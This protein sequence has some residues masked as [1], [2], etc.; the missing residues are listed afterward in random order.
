MTKRDA[1]FDNAKFLLI[2]LVVFGHFIQSYIDEHTLIRSL[3]LTIYTFH[4]PAFIFI[5]GYFA[6]GISDKGYILNLAKK[7]L[8]PYVIFQILY[9]LYYYYFANGSLMENN[10]FNPYWSLWFLLSM[11]YW[12][13]MIIFFKKFNW[14]YALLISLSISLTIGYF[15]QI[16][17]YL[18]LSRTFVFFPFFLIGF[19]V[20]REHLAKIHRPSIRIFSLAI[21][22]TVFVIFYYF[23]GFQ[24]QWLFGSKPYSYFETNQV[25]AML[26]RL[27]VYGISAITAIS[28]LS[29][30]PTRHAFFTK[31]GARSLYV[32]LLHGAFIKPF[33]SSDIKNVINGWDD[34]IIL[35]IVAFLI[36][37]VLSSKPVRVITQPFIEV[38]V[39]ALRKYFSKLKDYVIPSDK[40]K[41]QENH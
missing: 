34:F 23:N 28:C 22:A 36:T 37:L 33:R 11:F 2:F 8:L 24:E 1:Y 15:D 16:S 20:K 35:T 39:S 18:S 10:L 5:A 41:E 40:L 13:L 9:S 7:L 25:T 14:K 38:R 21:L 27:G 3:Y 31:L 17:N 29:L 26:I 6:K 30:I 12:N 19:F 4:M 32:Y